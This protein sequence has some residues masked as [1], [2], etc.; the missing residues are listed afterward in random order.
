MEVTITNKAEV[1][2]DQNIPDKLLN[3]N[4]TGV[5]TFS[6]TGPLSNKNLDIYFHIPEGD[7]QSLPV[8]FSFHG[9][10]RNAIDYRWWS[11]NYRIRTSF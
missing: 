7:L 2:N 1:D 9:G 5:F 11:I 6:P 3:S 8:L 10:S 4:S